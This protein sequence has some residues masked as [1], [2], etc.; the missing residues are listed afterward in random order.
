M[1]S[2]LDLWLRSFCIKVSQSSDILV[3]S[4]VNLLGLLVLFPLL[5]LFSYQLS[6]TVLS[7]D[8]YNGD[9]VSEKRDPENILVVFSLHVGGMCQIG[10]RKPSTPDSRA[11][12][13]KRIQIQNNKTKKTKTHS[14]GR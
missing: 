7:L 10:K 8:T 14:V 6:D 9:S 2:G 1:L 4:A 13:Q 5:L 3:A 12:V 11:A